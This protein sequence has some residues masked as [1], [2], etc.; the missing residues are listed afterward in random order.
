MLLKK[1]STGDNVKQIQTYLGIDVD[2]D[3]GPGTEAAVKE[4]QQKNNLYPDGIVGDKTWTLMF[5]N[6]RCVDSCITYSPIHTHISLNPKRDIKY[7]VLHFTAGS[8]STKGCA[9]NTRTVFLNRE[10]SADFIVD[11]ETI[12][13][14]N[15]DIKNYYCWAVGDKKYTNSNGATLYGKANNRNTINIEMCSTLQKGATLNVANHPGW[16]ISENVLSNTKRLVKILM[17][18]Y[19]ISPD[20]VIRHYDVT[21]KMCPGI[22]GWNNEHIYTIKGKATSNYSDSSEWEKFKRDLS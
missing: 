8:K 17:N 19:N 5:G 12:V 15:P 3:F 18:K 22:I 20:H 2:G 7:I 6:T 9:M 10:A 13:Q 16:S 14:V 4:Y 21:G 11:D 1:G